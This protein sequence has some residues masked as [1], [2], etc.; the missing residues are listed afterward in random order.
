MNRKVIAFLLGHILLLEAI[1]MIPAL[2]ISIFM[3]E[4]AAAWA[5]GITIVITAAVGLGLRLIRPTNMTFY[6]AEGFVVTALSWI[7]ISLFGGLPLS[8]IHI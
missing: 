8:L 1:V 7:A 2:A 4:K 3:A 6:A 5:L